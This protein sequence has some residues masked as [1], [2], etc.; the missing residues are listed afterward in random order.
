MVSDVPE[1]ALE[2]AIFPGQNPCPIPAPGG[3]LRMRIAQDAAGFSASVREL[4]GAGVRE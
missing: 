4:F 1:N 3:L 2:F